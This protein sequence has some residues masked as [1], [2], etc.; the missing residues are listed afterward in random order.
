M[1]PAATFLLCMAIAPKGTWR[2]HGIEFSREW[3]PVQVGEELDIDAPVPTVD[4]RTKEQIDHDVTIGAL[5]TRPATAAE[6]DAYLQ[7]L[8]EMK[9]K[10]PSVVISDLQKKNAE[11]EARLMKLELS[12]A[13][14]TKTGGDKGKGDGGKT[15]GDKG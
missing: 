10:D 12:A 8:A 9:G 13:G 15:G 1:E 2:V 7:Q 3:R 4:A 6:V 14:G 5:A 11:L